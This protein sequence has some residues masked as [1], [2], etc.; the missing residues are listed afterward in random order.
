MC[1][2]K[3]IFVDVDVDFNGM[4]FFDYPAI[5]SL[6]GGKIND[7]D[8]ILQEFTTTC[9]GDLVLDE[10]I[11]LPIMGIDDGRYLIRLFLN[12]KPSDE[13]RNIIFS[14]KYYY[15]KVTGDLYV[16]DMSVFWEWEDYAGWQNTDI[17]KGIYRVCLEGVHL[18]DGNNIIHC[19]DI[20]LEAITELGTRKI[21]P[22]AD[23]RL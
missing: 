5:L 19:Y 4:I 11:A 10:G 23:S 18:L 20:M 9:K 14:D 22:R 2:F 12:E 3:I 13:N 21:E 8:N 15:L 1:V 16:A 17:P 6:F 7:G